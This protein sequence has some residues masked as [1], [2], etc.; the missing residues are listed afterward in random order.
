MAKR[1]STFNKTG[2]VAPIKVVTKD[3]SFSTF[4][5]GF[6]LAGGC[7]NVLTVNNA[8]GMLAP[9]NEDIKQNYPYEAFVNFE[10]AILEK[11]RFAHLDIALA[12][13][14]R[15]IENN[16]IN[17]SVVDINSYIKSIAPL[18]SYSTKPIENGIELCALIEMQVIHSQLYSY[19]AFSLTSFGNEAVYALNQIIANY[20]NA[21][22]YAYA[23]LYN[24]LNKIRAIT[25]SRP[26]M[27]DKVHNLDGAFRNNILADL[28]DLPEKD[29]TDNSKVIIDDIK[30][31]IQVEAKLMESYDVRVADYCEVADYCDDDDGDDFFP[32]QF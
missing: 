3:I 7:T 15:A 4:Q 12:C 30:K 19:M 11:F 21:M 18:N 20:Y 6:Q 23:V 9:S 28:C 29:V 26:D 25:T 8:V 5:P 32:T 24:D 17:P 22:I 2:K 31:G 27:L 10:S 13:L 1:L 16:L 14:N